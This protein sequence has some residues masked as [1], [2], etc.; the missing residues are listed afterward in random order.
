LEGRVAQWNVAKL[1]QALQGIEALQNVAMYC[2]R[3]IM[4]QV[5]KDFAAPVA[6]MIAALAVVYVTAH[7][8]KEQ[9][10]LAREKLRHDLFERRWKIFSSIFDFYYAIIS[11]KGTTE[12]LEVRDRFF[13]AYQESRFLFSR[14]S[15]IEDVLKELNDKGAKVIG[16]KE[17]S[18]DFKSDLE[19]YLKYF[20][21]VQTIQ[22]HDFDVALTKVKNAMAE[23]LN[24][25]DL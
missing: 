20:N 12:Q 17:H 22:T 1:A 13:R 4:Y 11:W 2:N 16:F 18:E 25:H 10:R 15:G 5:L 21:E 8:N 3:R 24:F 9:T 7:F 19:M 6:T 14:E 23:Y